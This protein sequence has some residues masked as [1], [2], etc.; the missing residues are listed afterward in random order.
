M[1]SLR[2]SPG[3]RAYYHELTARKIGRHAAL[4][5]LARELKQKHAAAPRLKL[6]WKNKKRCY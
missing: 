5:K 3:A 2:G 4:K 6:A 1:C